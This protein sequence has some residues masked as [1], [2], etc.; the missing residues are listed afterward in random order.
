MTLVSKVGHYSRGGIASRADREGRNGAESCNDHNAHAFH[1]KFFNTL[2][3]QYLAKYLPI[4]R[5]FFLRIKL[6][7]F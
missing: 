1:T 2:A 4:S 5:L 6:H 3:K 7:S